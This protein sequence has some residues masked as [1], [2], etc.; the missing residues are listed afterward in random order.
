[1]QFKKVLS[2]SAIILLSTL[3]QGI[4]ATQV[5]AQPTLIEQ[6]DLDSD[7]QISIREAVADPNILAVFGKIDTDGDGKISQQ[8][9]DSAALRKETIQKS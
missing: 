7:G 9:L 6:M 2:M 5:F 4:T 1:M 8:E 3:I